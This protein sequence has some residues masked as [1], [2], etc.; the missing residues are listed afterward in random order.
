M[1]FNPADFGATPVSSGGFNPSQFG[2]TPVAPT[3]PTHA[4]DSFASMAVNAA[5]GV[6]GNLLNTIFPGASFAGSAISSGFNHLMNAPSEI[7]D[8]FNSG[9]SQIG[10]GFNQ[11]NNGSANPLNP[12]ESALKVGSGAVSALSSPLAP[13]MNAFTDASGINETSNQIVQGASNIP[14][15]QNFAM[16]PQGEATSR[17]VG[18]VGNA[19]NIAGAVTGFD[20]VKALPDTFAGFAQKS[21]GGMSPNAGPTASATLMNKVARI[22][23]SDAEH[24]SHMSGGTTPGGFLDARGIYG[25]PQSVVA[26]LFDRFTQSKNAVDSALSNLPGLY[27]NSAVETALKDVVDQAKATSA[28]GAPSPY[29]S[30]AQNLLARIQHE[31]LD[32][33]SINAAKRLY[34]ST[35]KT[36]YIKDGVSA[37]IERANN[38]DSSIRTW[39][40]DAANKL[41]FTNIQGLNKETQLSKML[42]D[43]MGKKANAQLG[44]NLVGLTDWIVASGVPHDPSSLALLLGKKLFDSGAGQGFLAKTLSK[45]QKLPAPSAKLGAMNTNPA[46]LGLPGKG[47]T[48]YVNNLPPVVTPKHAGLLPA[49]KTGTISYPIKTK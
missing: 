48:A 10:E 34:E 18:A 13:V 24:F 31:G 21:E 6:G 35:V 9:V 2:A 8:A 33:S 7:G 38:I 47:G 4:P 41:G 3:A 44:N 16:S 45:G 42:M 28:E 22:N 15:V 37:G 11:A 30:Q 29:L 1:A 46:T 19:A 26:Q 43:S 27:K 20:G 49:D 25:S 14:A 39:Q 12:I 40:Q 32:M 17:A 23:P 36:N 5:K